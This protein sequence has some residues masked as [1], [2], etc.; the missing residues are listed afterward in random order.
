ML[1]IRWR[2]A[3]WLRPALPVSLAQFLL[4]AVASAVAHAGPPENLGGPGALSDLRVAR[5]CTSHPTHFCPALEIVQRL[6]AKLLP[7]TVQKQAQRCG[8]SGG[9]MDP[10]VGSCRRRYRNLLRVIFEHGVVQFKKNVRHRC[11]G[12]AVW[13]KNHYRRPHSEHRIHQSDP[14]SRAAT[15][16]LWW[17]NTNQNRSFLFVPTESLKV[18]KSSRNGPT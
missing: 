14:V 9:Y 4:T 13:K 18:S 8:L 11:G 1:F 5:G 3:P 10:R 12:F 15:F 6:S 17:L 16:A 7:Q 2:G